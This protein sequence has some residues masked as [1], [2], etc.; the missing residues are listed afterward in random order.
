METFRLR[1]GPAG[2]R[3]R[4]AGKQRALPPL[5]RGTKHF[6]AWFVLFFNF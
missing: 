1:A 5:F 4:E 2:G 3:S 6:S